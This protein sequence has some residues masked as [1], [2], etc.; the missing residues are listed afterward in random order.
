M[1][2]EFHAHFRVGNLVE[3]NLEAIF[4]IVPDNFPL[5]EA[6]PLV[7]LVFPFFLLFAYLAGGF[8]QFENAVALRHHRFREFRVPLPDIGTGT[9]YEFHISFSGNRRESSGQIVHEKR[10]VVASFFARIQ[11]MD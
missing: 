11:S 1:S 7:L 8:R 9:L 3:D 5:V 10:P 6:D 2:L 4:G